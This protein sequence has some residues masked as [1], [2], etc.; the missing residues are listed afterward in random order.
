MKTFA[1]FLLAALGA[2]ALTSCT[3]T[4]L[5]DGSLDGQIDPAAIPLI[6]EILADK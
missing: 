5:P 2:A 6:L 3:V 1:C 4:R